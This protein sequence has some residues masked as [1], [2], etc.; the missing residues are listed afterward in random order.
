MF[1]AKIVS[2]QAW[3][4]NVDVQLESTAD[5]WKNIC[6]SW[7]NIVPQLHVNNSVGTAGCT[8][9]RTGRRMGLAGPIPHHQKTHTILEKSVG[10][11]ARKHALNI[12][13]Y[14]CLDK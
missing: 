8:I 5:I 4:Q 14:L 9:L 6:P 12:T 10:C 2:T 3:K 7:M 13:R 11:F 1:L